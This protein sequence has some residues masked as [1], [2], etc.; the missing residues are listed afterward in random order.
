MTRRGTLA[1]YLAAWVIGCFIVAVP[2][3]LMD[4]SPGQ[5][6]W[7][8]MF[9]VTYFYALFFGAVDAL[10][11][12]F[13]LRQLMRLFRT[14]ALWAWLLAGMSIAF[15]LTMTIAWG[16]DLVNLLSDIYITGRL[17]GL[18]E[19]VLAMVWLAPAALR[20]G[21]VFWQV[22]IDGAVGG[23]VLCLI[24]RAFNRP[25]EQVEAHQPAA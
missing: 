24:D 11:F 3:S 7:A 17:Q 9:L 18:V 6:S 8:P 16:G 21:T 15:A 19:E 12:A 22:P 2:L 13:L 1:Y 23:V 10:L 20:H 14:H 4:S 25:D 5:I